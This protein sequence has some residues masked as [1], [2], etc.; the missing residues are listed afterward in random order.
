MLPRAA[1]CRPGGIALG[2]HRAAALGEL[3]AEPDDLA[4]APKVEAVL[5]CRRGG[6]VGCGG[7]VGATQGEGGMAPVG[8]PDDEVRISSSAEA[9]DRDPLAAEGVMRMGNGHESRRWLG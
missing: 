9:N 5:G 2:R 1:A 7:V 6:V 3:I 8:E 4:Q